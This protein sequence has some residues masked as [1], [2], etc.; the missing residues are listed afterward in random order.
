M[1][2]HVFTER[3]KI[4][5]GDIELGCDFNE[6]DRGWLLQESQKKFPFAELKLK[7]MLFFIVYAN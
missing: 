4:G 1:S 5:G 6:K 2:L 7:Q 3:I